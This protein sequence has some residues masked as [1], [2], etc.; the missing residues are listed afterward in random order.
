MMRSKDRGGRTGY[1][2]Y[3]D[4]DYDYDNRRRGRSYSRSPKRSV[5]RFV[6]LGIATD[7]NND[8]YLSAV[9]RATQ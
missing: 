3:D 8:T 9:F 7:V 1:D 5:F 4:E 2:R 6:L